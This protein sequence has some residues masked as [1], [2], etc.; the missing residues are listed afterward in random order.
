MNF[1]GSFTVPFHVRDGVI[2]DAN[3]RKVKLWGVNYYVPFNHNFYNL[4][5][6]GKD[7]FAAIDEDIRHFRLLGVDFIRMHLYDREITDRHGNIVENKN[8]A[9]FDYLVE[10]CAQNGIYLM[11]TPT[12]WWNTVKTQI[13]MERFYAFWNIG[14]QDAFGFSNYYANDAM[15]WDPDAIACQQNY[16]EQLFT[17]ASTS[18]G[19]RLS[20]YENVV[21]IELFNEPRYPN[22]YLL[23]PDPDLNS[24]G[25]MAATRPRGE[26]RQLFV[27]MWQAFTT[28]HPDEK[29]EDRRFSLFSA[30]LMQR[31]F[32]AL[33][34]I[35]R[36]H[37][38]Q[39]VLTAQHIGS[40]ST[41]P[42]TTKAFIEAADIDAST[43]CTYL[44][45]HSFDAVNTDDCNHL[46]YAAKWLDKFAS[47]D[48]GRLGKIAYE[49]N[50][51]ATTN[52]YPLAAIAAIYAQL[53]V[54]LAAY[55]TY[56]PAAIAAWNPGW[57][58]HYLNIAHTPSRAAGFAAAGDI[59]RQHNP[60]DVIAMTPEAWSGNNYAIERKNDFVFSRDNRVFRY[61]GDNDIDPGDIAAL[62]VVSGRGSSRFVASNGNGFYHL[63]RQDAATWQ[64][65]L[66][67]RQHYVIS[68]ER[69][70]Q[71]R[72]MANRY[73]NCLQEPPVSILREERVTFTMKAFKVT[74]ATSL[75]NGS[76]IA[77]DQNGTLLLKPGE[78]L[79]HL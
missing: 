65:S 16:L 9:V 59:F 66:F 35:V 53:D 79:L 74:S 47:I 25:M 61:S 20:E 49:F 12:V 39:R 52:G 22:R 77:P 31:Y 54:Q 50:A 57:L 8:L 41:F 34:P 2:Y 26:Q 58:V 3:D 32:G 45:V 21:A 37:F 29:D 56:T 1:A 24:N 7:H 70:R 28:E 38:G 71:Y 42:G 27:R 76:S 62:R 6:L 44:N 55:F 68:P 10:Q 63:A 17:R 15:L 46:T 78:Y 19:K 72:S 33:L 14:A 36:K 11:I 48:F 64:L 23:E 30:Q 69:S 60:G 4:E 43:L 75:A 18:S 40:E 67:P 51:T 73:I 13:M 5:E